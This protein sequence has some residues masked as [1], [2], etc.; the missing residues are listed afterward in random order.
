MLRKAL[1]NSILFRFG[2]YFRP[3]LFCSHI[4][5]EFPLEIE[6]TGN[7]DLFEQHETGAERTD[8]I[9][10]PA[11][12]IDK[13]N[14]ST[15]D[16]ALGSTIYNCRTFQ[17]VFDQY[18]HPEGD[19]QGCLRPADSHLYEGIP[20]TS[21]HEIITGNRC[22]YRGYCCPG[23]LSNPGKVFKRFS[24]HSQNVTQRIQKSPGYRFI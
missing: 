3:A 4:C 24:G 8:A 14:T 5:S 10:L 7:F 11:N 21:G 15:V 16:G 2:A 13:G 9:L 22:H 12:R 6:S 23:R 19:I 1:R 20:G 18:L 17:T